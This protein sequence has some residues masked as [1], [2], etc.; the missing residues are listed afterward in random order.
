M[1]FAKSSIVSASGKPSNDAATR[2]ERLLDD[3]IVV[4]LMARDGVTRADILSVIED[5]RHGLR[6]RPLREAA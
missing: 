5:V 3:P 2:V 1:P 6:R 4:L